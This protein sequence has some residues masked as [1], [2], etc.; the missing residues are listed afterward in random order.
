M[1]KSSIKNLTFTYVFKHEFKIV[2]DVMKDFAKTNRMCELV[3]KGWSSPPVFQKMSHSYELG[4]EFYFVFKNFIKL[5]L[6]NV[7]VEEFEDFAKIRYE[8]QPDFNVIPN[9]EYTYTLYGDLTGSYCTLV[10]EINYEKIL[11]KT[12]KE[13]EEAN[14]ELF[15]ILKN[16]EKCIEEEKVMKMQIEQIQIN[17]SFQTVWD[18]ILNFKDFRRINPLICDEVEY[19]GEKLGEGMEVI[20]KWTRKYKSSVKLQVKQIRKAFDFCIL[21]FESLESCPPV[22]RQKIEWRLEKKECDMCNVKLTHNYNEI[23]KKES[24]KYTSKVK[25]KILQNLKRKVEESS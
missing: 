3:I 9:Y 20:F 8:V 19:E 6:K 5:N 7:E 21:I 11:Y 12:K 18:M 16:I 4:S 15:I 23:I 24:L 14:L 2:W 22:P 17:K 10:L 25:K 13:K 1:K